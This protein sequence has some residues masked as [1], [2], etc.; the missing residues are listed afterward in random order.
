MQATLAGFLD[1]HRVKV[2]GFMVTGLT[3]TAS[4]MTTNRSITQ[5]AQNMQI[6]SPK[7][8]VI[9]TCKTA[10]VWPGMLI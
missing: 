4:S 6:L 9:T 7:N 10:C 3:P 1:N 8:F 5:P 2:R